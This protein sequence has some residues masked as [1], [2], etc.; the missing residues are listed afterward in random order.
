[1]TNEEL[2]VLLLDKLGWDY[3]MVANPWHYKNT[4]DLLMGDLI[5]AI[6]VTGTTTA[7]AIHLK[8]PY[9]TV[10]TA[11]TRFMVPIFGNLQGGGETWKWKFLTYLNLQYCSDCKKLL[12]F[13]LFGKDISNSVGYYKYCKNCR[14]RH[15]SLQYTK[16]I[17]KEAHRRS[18]KKNYKN[19]VA[20]NASYRSE[21]A[22]RIP[23]WAN[24]EKISQVYKNCPTGMHIDHE[25]PL[26]GELICGL[27]VPE[28]LQYL[29]A[30]DNIRKGNRI[31]LD[32]YNKKHFGT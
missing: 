18:Y 17:T 31:D 25:L 3:D 5:Y 20:R 13:S 6:L 11:T 19:I 26:K 30:E 14:V 8:I 28:N 12:D 32:A 22:L 9:K 10:L 1:M 27:H 16:E 21:R 4:T 15:N 7:A 29:T 2:T 23:K 24:L